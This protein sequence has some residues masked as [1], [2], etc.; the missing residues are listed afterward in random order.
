LIRHAARR[1]EGFGGLWHLINHSAALAE[2]ARHGYRELAIKGLPAFREHFRLFKT[3]P[4]VSEEKGA[5]TS[6]ADAPL[7]PDFWIPERIRRERA[8]LTHRIKTIYGFDALSELV[9]DENR[10]IQAGDRL[11]YLM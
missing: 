2:L 5:E 4:D 8:H 3:L 11:R 10:R 6:T 7:T 1:R 9:P